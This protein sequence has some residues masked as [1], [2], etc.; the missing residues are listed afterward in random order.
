METVQDWR[1]RKRAELALIGA[2]LPE[3]PAPGPLP[4][5]DAVVREK[6]A[7]RARLIAAATLDLPDLVET[8]RLRTD[9]IAFGD[10]TLTWRYQRFDLELQGPMPYPALRA[11]APNVAR[12]DWTSSGMGSIAAILLGLQWLKW[13][14]HVLIRHDAYFETLAVLRDLCPGVT[15]TVIPPGGDLRAAADAARAE[16]HERVL[17]WGDSFSQ[18]DPAPDVAALPGAPIDHVVFDTTC[19]EASS[20]RLVTLRDACFAA[21]TPLTL[22]RSHVKIDFLGV[23]WGRLGSLFHLIAPHFTA[24][25]I[26]Q[27]RQFAWCSSQTLRRI[28]ATAIPLHL[29]PF[30]SDPAFQALNRGRVARIVAANR[31]A[32]KALRQALAGSPVPVRTFHHD[33]FVALGIFGESVGYEAARAASDD[34]VQTLRQAGVAARL[35]NSFG[36]DFA[37]AAPFRDPVEFWD[38]LRLAVPDWPDT[39]IDDLVERVARWAIAR[40]TA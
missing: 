38:E 35:A 40:R 30:L 33:L 9:S 36:F 19:Y 2:R 17:W 26:D 5:A 37:A 39:W 29:N 13:S 8:N 11:G 34:L 3:A 32:G 31:R 12:V 7:L 24:E 15:T 14:A 18:E 21:G 23:E 16:G 1:A 6:L 4:D 25:R 10:F 20:P 22:V 28:G 27:F